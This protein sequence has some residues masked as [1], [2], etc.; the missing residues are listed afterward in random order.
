MLML[1]KVE[2]NIV[3]VFDFLLLFGHVY[4]IFCPPRVVEKNSVV[5]HVIDEQLKSITCS[6]GFIR[7]VSEGVKEKRIHKV[8]SLKKTAKPFNRERLLAN[9]ICEQLIVPTC[10]DVFDH[11]KRDVFRIQVEGGWGKSGMG[12]GAK[13]PLPLIF[14][15]PPPSPG[16]K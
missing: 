4:M 11:K 13:N 12:G 5:R 3:S 10:Q 7:E 2:R 6:K 1:G 9:L 15:Y 14:F 16:Y 8:A